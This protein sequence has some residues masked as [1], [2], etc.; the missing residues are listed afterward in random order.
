[1]V[2]QNQPERNE[3]RQDHDPLVRTLRT[4]DDPDL[5]EVADRWKSLPTE[6]KA[7]VMLLVRQV[8]TP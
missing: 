2:W 4:P 6:I 8:V 3:L 1:V 7:E 5:A